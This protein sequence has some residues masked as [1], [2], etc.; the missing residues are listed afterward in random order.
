MT[1]RMTNEP[2]A[3]LGSQ[4]GGAGPWGPGPD[5]FPELT[6]KTPFY[7]KPRAPS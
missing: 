5:T 4:K 1:A 3:Q 2:D 6:Q 7:V